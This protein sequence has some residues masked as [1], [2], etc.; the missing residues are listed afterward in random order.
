M[1]IPD[2]DELSHTD[3]VNVCVDHLEKFHRKIV[4]VEFAVGIVKFDTRIRPDVFVRYRVIPILVA[5]D[6]QVYVPM[7]LAVGQLVYSHR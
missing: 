6:D 1:S 4:T 7:V 3:T 5:Q 2:I